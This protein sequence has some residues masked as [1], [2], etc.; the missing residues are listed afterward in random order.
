MAYKFEHEVVREILK[1]TIADQNPHNTDTRSPWYSLSDEALNEYTKKVITHLERV[2]DSSLTIAHAI[3]LESKETEDLSIEARQGILNHLIDK[4]NQ[5]L[6]NTPAGDPAHAAKEKRLA[7]LQDELQKLETVSESFERSKE[8]TQQTL[9]LPNHRFHDIGTGQNPDR[10]RVYMAVFAPYTPG[11]PYRDL[12]LD[13]KGQLD[14]KSNQLWIGAGTPYKAL[15]WLQKYQLDN[16]KDT[17]DRKKKSSPEVLPGQ[18]MIR[19][20][21]VNRTF[22]DRHLPEATPEGGVRYGTVE[23]INEPRLMY[24]DVKSFNQL[25]L[26]TTTQS[27]TQQSALLRSFLENA[28]PETLETISFKHNLRSRPEG[29][30]GKRVDVQNF[31]KDL[32]ISVGGEGP[33]VYLFDRNNTMFHTYKGDTWSFSTTEDQIKKVRSLQGMLT[34]LEQMHS[35]TSSLSLA[36]DGFETPAPEYRQAPAVAPISPTSSR[37]SDDTD[38]G[39]LADTGSLSGSDRSSISSSQSD[40]QSDLGTRSDISAQDLE[41]RASEEP[42]FSTNESEDRFFTA[43]SGDEDD[44]HPVALDLFYSSDADIEDHGPTLPLIVDLGSDENQATI[45]NFGE[46]L[47]INHLTPGALVPPAKDISQNQRDTRGDNLI[48]VIIEDEIATQLLKDRSRKLNTTVEGLIDYLEK[49]RS[50]SITKLDENTTNASEQLIKQ[51]NSK[52]PDNEYVISDIKENKAI[53]S[54]VESERNR[55]FQTSPLI[56]KVLKNQ[57]VQNDLMAICRNTGEKPSAEL[58][59]NELRK[60]ATGEDPKSRHLG[61][62]LFF[63]SLR[64]VAQEINQTPGV[65]RPDPIPHKMIA[66]EDGN[67]SDVPVNNRLQKIDYSALLNQTPQASGLPFDIHRSTVN[68]VTNPKKAATTYMNEL[69]TPFKGGISGTTRDICKALPTIAPNLPSEE[70][71]DLFLLNAAFMVKNQYHSM[72][73]ALYPVARYDTGDMGKE[74]LKTFDECRDNNIGTDKK[75]N[76]ELY[77]RTLYQMTKS[78]ELWNATIKGIDDK[79]QLNKNL[80]EPPTPNIDGVALNKFNREDDASRFKV[81]DIQYDKQF[82]ILSLNA[83]QRDPNKSRCYV[84]LSD[85]SK[86]PSI[87]N[88]IAMQSKHNMAEKKRSVNPGQKR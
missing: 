15:G 57:L 61:A 69:D 71:N 34:Q 3:A 7:D 81:S 75:S 5:S 86:L 28:H 26:D 51:I 82:A 2:Q 29:I 79:L 62:N 17:L 73:E 27:N 37:M 85:L 74:L 76:T 13:D 87:G 88:Q 54:Q 70:K 58:F 60:F 11:S 19:S 21:E 50:E 66:G 18:P 46:F 68:Y 25:G 30:D 12:I 80:I 65:V 14:A 23:G 56:Q 45:K 1:A 43:S 52:S 83:Q 41:S 44:R 35:K 47:T 39:Y 33:S 6:A 64:I 24:V 84:P 78:T 40:A 32:G 59:I 67:E 42:Y 53:L 10:V 72:F 4:Q 55:L 49:S 22:F 20:V 48:K 16:N 63:H 9:T 8:Q 31:M 36:S 38:S 77:Q